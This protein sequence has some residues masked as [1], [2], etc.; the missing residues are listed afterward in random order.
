MVAG[1]VGTAAAAL[2]CGCVAAVIGNA[3]HSGT[4]ADTRAGAYSAAPLDAAVRTRLGAD[5]AL[6]GSPISV[7]AAG[8]TVTLR[9]TVATAA[10]R[11]EAERMARTVAGVSVVNNQLRVN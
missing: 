2:L 1:T 9:G 10:Q 11:A 7:S 6:R 8:G 3:T 5:A 4:A